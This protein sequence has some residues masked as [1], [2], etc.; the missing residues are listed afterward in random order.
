MNNITINQK[1]LGEYLRLKEAAQYLGI[2][3]VTLHRLTENDQTFPPKI[4]I[5][6]RCCVFKRKSLDSWLTSKES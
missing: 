1:P 6:S 3:R 4:H 2:S 5:T